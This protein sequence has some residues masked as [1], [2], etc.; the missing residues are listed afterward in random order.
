[1]CWFA[2][3][4]PHFCRDEAGEDGASLLAPD[5]LPIQL[6]PGPAAA[7][8]ADC[9]LQLQCSTRGVLDALPIKAVDAY[10]NLVDSCSFDVSAN[11]VLCGV[12]CCCACWWR[13]LA[14]CSAGLT[15]VLYNTC[16]F[17]K[18]LRCCQIA[19]ASDAPALVPCRCR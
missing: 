12:L 7:L 14:V 15:T 17:N 1:V 9:P 18:G 5:E 19:H 16:C 11:M 2:D 3:V 8:V 13:S 10:G 6:L 4:A